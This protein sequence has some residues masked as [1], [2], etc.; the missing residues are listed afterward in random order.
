MRLV[1]V[2]AGIAGLMFA[3]AGAMAQVTQTTSAPPSQNPPRLAAATSP[4]LDITLFGGG[5][6][7]QDYD[8]TDEGIQI[9]QSLTQ[10][11]GLVGRATGYQLYLTQN[12][13]SPLQASSNQTEA[14]LNFGRFE[15][16]I[17]ISPAE[18]TNLYLLGGHD[19]GDS[20]AFVVEGDLSTWQLQS[21]N[22]PINLFIAPLYDTQNKVTSSEIDLRMVATRSPDWTVVVGAGGA[23]YGGGFIHG[24]DG[25]GGP[26]LGLY[27]NLW[28]LGADLQAGYGTPGAYGE[29]TIYKTFSIW[30]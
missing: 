6:V 22:H 26:I 10:G 28:K 13:V 7:S 27:N 2:F 8:D 18:G 11:L 4:H 20:D 1:A 30:E 3:S 5:F 23:V 17:D 15:G 12:S 16:G 14:R 9:E 24:A 19:V 29:L 21:T 25:Q